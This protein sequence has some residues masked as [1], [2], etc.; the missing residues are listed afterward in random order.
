[1][2]LKNK[3]M[4]LKA[5]FAGL[6]A[7]V[8]TVLFSVPAM[9]VD[10]QT[11]VDEA[12]NPEYTET[13]FNWSCPD[14]GNGIS[15]LIMTIFNFFSMGVALVVVAGIILGG[16]QY[17]TAMGDKTKTAKAVDTIRNCVIAL[18]LYIAFWIIMNFLV[19]GGM[20]ESK[21]TVEGELSS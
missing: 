16:I 14:G 9:A 21:G 3:F 7:T 5:P 2:Q 12:G 18:V 17:S 10:C 20:F 1:M 13:Y 11:G 19:P 15:G 4:K 6:A 8:L